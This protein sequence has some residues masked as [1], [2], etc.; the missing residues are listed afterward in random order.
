MKVTTI[1]RKVSGMGYSNV[2][3]TASI[4]EEEDPIK[5]MIELDQRCEQSLK[6]IQ[7]SQSEICLRSNKENVMLQKV[8]ALTKAIQNHEVDDLPF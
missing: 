4:S 8:A 6:A 1:S 5:A 2:E 3:M 7:E